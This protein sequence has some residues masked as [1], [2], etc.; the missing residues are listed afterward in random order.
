MIQLKERW[1]L[2]S[3]LLVENSTFLGCYKYILMQRKN[4]VSLCKNDEKKLQTHLDYRRLYTKLQSRLKTLFKKQYTLNP[5]ND[6]LIQQNETG[7]V[8]SALTSC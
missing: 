2:S 1:S 8:S 6:D 5:W 4:L 7:H 3:Y